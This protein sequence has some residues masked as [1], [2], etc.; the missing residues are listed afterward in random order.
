[1]Y[2]QPLHILPPR[3]RNQRWFFKPIY[4][5]IFDVTDVD[6]ICTA[7][8]SHVIPSLPIACLTSR[9]AQF[10]R[11]KYGE[12]C[13]AD[14]TPARLPLFEGCCVASGGCSGGKF[15][16]KVVRVSC[17]RVLK[18]RDFHCFIALLSPPSYRNLMQV[19]LIFKR[20]AWSL[21]HAVKC[22]LLSRRQWG[23]S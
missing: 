16:D 17:E 12:L 13:C 21:I 6:L 8:S 20:T 3:Q 9:C 11:R 10:L 2:D 1:M 15:F 23:V 7:G 19:K 14:S 22:E 4:K 18:T 5:S